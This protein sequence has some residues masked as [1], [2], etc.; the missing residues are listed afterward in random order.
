MIT[1]VN[2]IP[3]MPLAQSIK[4]LIPVVFV[5]LMVILGLFF[6]ARVYLLG[7]SLEQIQA[8]V[9]KSEA[10]QEQ[11]RVLA[12]LVASLEG[13]TVRRKEQ[14][15]KK[16]RV[17]DRLVSID[18]EKRR[19]TQSLFLIAETL[20]PTIRC[21]TITFSGQTGSL[22]GTALDYD[23]LATLVKELQDD[24]LV[25]NVS[26]AVTSRDNQQEMEKIQFSIVLELV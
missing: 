16:R 3:K 20:P 7:N 11:K 1:R 12:N 2:L 5:G 17:V 19:F 9:A 22:L 10:V 26:L 23:D 13:N 21:Q 4:G 15:Q 6:T 25:A 24:P 8:R 14:L 18:A